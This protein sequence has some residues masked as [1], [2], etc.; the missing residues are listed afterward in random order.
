[1][2][3][4]GGSLQIACGVLSTLEVNPAF[5][6]AALTPEMLATDLAEYLVRKGVP[7]RDAH[8]LAGA[9]VRMAELQAI[10]LSELEVEDL[11]SIH[12]AFDED[13]EFHWTVLGGIR[14]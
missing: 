12:E 4:V 5:M 2:T 8:H 13:A 9:A 10:P 6:A 11:L 1:M 7:F 14:F 3:N